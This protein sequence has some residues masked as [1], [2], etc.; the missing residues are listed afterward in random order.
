MKQELATMN[1]TEEEESF[2]GNGNSMPEL[3]K[4]LKKLKTESKKQEIASEDLLD[5]R[6]AAHQKSI[7]LRI[8][9]K[10]WSQRTR[11]FLNSVQG[12]L[13]KLLEL[14]SGMIE[15][16]LDQISTEYSLPFKVMMLVFKVGLTIPIR[17]DD[18]ECCV[19]RILRADRPHF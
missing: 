3:N 7:V 18:A 10:V 6:V 17:R 5:K 13:F 11:D 12:W 4:Q 1:L 14:F 15:S 16:V 19:S 9:A 2:L 8:K